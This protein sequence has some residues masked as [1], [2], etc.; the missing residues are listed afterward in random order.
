M[1]WKLELK[2]FNL[3]SKLANIGSST[4]QS[5][6]LLNWSNWN[7]MKYVVRWAIW[8]YLNNLENVKNAHQTLLGGYFSRF[9]NGAKWRNASHMKVSLKGTYTLLHDTSTCRADLLSITGSNTF[10]YSFYATRWVEGKMWLI[11]PLRYGP[12]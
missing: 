6:R 9:L 5:R 1:S 10:S 12:V 7:R 3:I 2:T 4:Q 11:R 8:Y